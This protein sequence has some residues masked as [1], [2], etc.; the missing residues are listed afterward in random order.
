[1]SVGKHRSNNTSKKFCSQRIFLDPSCI[2]SILDLI[3]N[4]VKTRVNSGEIN[5][6]AL[7]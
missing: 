2:L 6:S 3:K 4:F 7:K 5:N 1:M